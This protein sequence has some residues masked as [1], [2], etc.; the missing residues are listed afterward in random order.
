MDV[1]QCSLA[2]LTVSAPAE[3]GPD[4]RPSQTAAAAGTDDDPREQQPPP[5]SQPQRQGEGHEAAPS[6]SATAALI[7]T[8]NAFCSKCRGHG[9]F[10]PKCYAITDA[11]AGRNPEHTRY[12]VKAPNLTPTRFHHGLPWSGL[13]Y[14]QLEIM[15]TSTG[16]WKASTSSSSTHGVSGPQTYGDAVALMI[17]CMEHLGR[18]NTFKPA[19]YELLSDMGAE[20]ERH[21]RH[22]GRQA[23][24]AL[25]KAWKTHAE[26][27]IDVVERFVSHMVLTIRD[28]ERTA[29]L[30]PLAVEIK[31]Y[32]KDVGSTRDE[33]TYSD[34]WEYV[35]AHLDCGRPDDQGSGRSKEAAGI[36]ETRSLDPKHVHDLT[37]TMAALRAHYDDCLGRLREWN[38]EQSWWPEVG[39]R[40]RIS[41]ALE[42]VLQMPPRLVP[43]LGEPDLS[44]ALNIQ[45]LEW[46]DLDDVWY[47]WRRAKRQPSRVVPLY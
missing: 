44:T 21:S 1:Q 11:F 40:L 20:V 3:L 31:Q 4:Q 45:D 22:L 39:V 28:F 19:Q 37:S 6:S 5:P 25:T 38:I 27:T 47:E 23:S 18:Y 10:S 12:L 30:V 41:R 7:L 24:R 36:L 16:E 9:H 29:I 14:R 2:G 8:N 42:M 34:V 33:V 46:P 13:P 17:S 26:R 35:I 15:K 43:T 32:R